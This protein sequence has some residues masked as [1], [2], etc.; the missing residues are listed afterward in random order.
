MRV[1]LEHFKALEALQ[2]RG[3]SQGRSQPCLWGRGEYEPEAAR[4]GDALSKQLCCAGNVGPH[5]LHLLSP[6]CGREHHHHLAILAPEGAA[7]LLP[8]RL[9][10][11]RVH[12]GM[13]DKLDPLPPR[14][15]EV[16]C[17]CGV[18]GQDRVAVGDDVGCPCAVPEPLVGGDV[19]DVLALWVGVPDV[20]GERDVD[21]GIVD[22]YGDVGRGLRQSP[23]HLLL[24]LEGRQYQRE[25][26][27]EPDG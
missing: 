26:L 17:L 23:P 25:R 20:L 22:E 19:I 12:E 1:P 6:A 11:D 24:Q 5:E 4:I 9:P 7:G 2:P 21:A 27:L 16:M 8:P 13:A 18:H 15:A 10:A 3:C 14:S